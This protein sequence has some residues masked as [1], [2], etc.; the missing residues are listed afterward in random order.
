MVEMLLLG[1]CVSIVA[2]LIAAFLALR[3]QQRRLIR[4]QAQ[5]EAWQRTQEMHQ[6]HWN[7][8]QEKR[9]AEFEKKLTTQV[10]EVRTDWQS[11]KAN[12]AQRVE[13]LAEQYKRITDKAELEFALAQ[14][15]R[16]EEVSLIP[17]EN[18]LRQPARLQGAE[19]A[20][21]DLSKRYLG[22]A[23]L[24]HAN[25]AHANLSL[26]DLSGAHLTGANLTG[27]NL[28]GANLSHADLRGA[29]LTDANL[30]VADLNSASLMGAILT[31]I[32]SLSDEQLAMALYDDTTSFDEAIEVTLPR[33]PRIRYPLNGVPASAPTKVKETPLPA[34]LM[35]Q[36][37]NIEQNEMVIHAQ[38]PQA[39]GTT[40]IPFMPVYNG[41]NGSNGS[42]GHNGHNGSNG[43]HGTKHTS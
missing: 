20:G 22:Y 17:G 3:L 10:Q 36:G 42:H 38:G 16:V 37:Y 31:G 43:S 4:S 2:A 27:A 1:G 28:S 13:N 12:D 41:H 25:L 34:S 32:R 14:L 29:I 6:Q 39:K 35:S 19:L 11:W 15:P 23:D 40:P 5:Q 9:T 18:T 33:V 30:L 26:S 7:V 21:R 8:L 24:R